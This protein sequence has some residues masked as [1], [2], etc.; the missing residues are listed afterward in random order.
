MLNWLSAIVDA[1]FVVS[2]GIFVDPGFRGMRLPEAAPGPRWVRQSVRVHDARRLPEPPT[3]DREGFELVESRCRLDF[4]APR[5]VTTDFY[6]HCAELVKAATGC[7]QAQTVQHEFRD[8]RGTPP[9]GGR[10][11]ARIAHADLSP[12]LEEILT[13]PGGRHYAVFNVWRS[14]DFDHPVETMPLAVCDVRTVA[15]RDITYADARRMTKPATKFVECRLIHDPGQSWFYFPRMTSD[16]ALL[17]RQY[18]TR[19]EHPG[20]RATYHM[21]FEDPT[22][23]DDAPDR[24][25][26]EARVLAVF[27][28]RDPDPAGRLARFRAQVPTRWPDGRVSP[29]R[30]EPMVD[31][32]TPVAAGRRR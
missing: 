31:W 26:V 11:Y 2:T 8:P 23:R 28:E 25:S 16:E 27:R 3:L 12:Y 10:P 29:W 20:R 5:V 22:T 32:I 17:F 18:D 6:E 14:V 30:H 4:V 13:V 21:A 15:A 9:L 1:P 24:V 7:V 19:R